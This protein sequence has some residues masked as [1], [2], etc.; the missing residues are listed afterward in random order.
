MSIWIILYLWACVGFAIATD[1][2]NEDRV[3]KG[4]PARLRA[5]I[6]LG[7]VGPVFLPAI[8][9]LCV[10]RVARR[11]RSFVKVLKEKSDA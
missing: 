11:E 5:S 1:F 6:F 3:I 9:T 4:K 10:L 7:A 2:Y 8:V